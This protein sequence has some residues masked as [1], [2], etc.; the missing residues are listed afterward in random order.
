M[1]LFLLDSNDAMYTPWG[2]GITAQLYDSS[3]DRRLL[4]KIVLG[5]GGWKLIERLGVEKPPPK[6]S[7]LRKPIEC[8]IP[9]FYAP[10]SQW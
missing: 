4:Q 8:D 9:D 10:N 1:R 5:V 7:G 3:Q 6:Y 2:R